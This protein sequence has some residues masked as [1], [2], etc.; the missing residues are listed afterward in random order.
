MHH[1]TDSFAWKI[2][3]HK[4][5]DFGCEPRNLCLALS[6]DGVNPF[7]N[8]STQC[9]CWPVILA[10]YNL[11]SWLVMKRKF[12][13]LTLLISG[14]KQPGNDIDVYLASLIDDLK[15][16]WEVGVDVYDAYKKVLENMR[17]RMV[18]LKKKCFKHK[19]NRSKSH[20]VKYNK[21]NYISIPLVA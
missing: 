2:V 9:S 1:P 8:Y 18:D 6:V 12:M 4:W 21:L 13:I 17:S 10:T 11:P 3:D 19:T 7:S 20:D 14:P 16:L 5:P 15:K